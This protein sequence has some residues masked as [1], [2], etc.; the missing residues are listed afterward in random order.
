MIFQTFEKY[1]YYKI[2]VLFMSKDNIEKSI[3]DVLKSDVRFRI[4]SLLHLYPELSFSEI[5]KKMNKSKST[6]HHHLK[7]L[8]DYDIIELSRQEKVRGNILAKYYSLKPGYL[9]KL[10]KTDSEIDKA[11]PSTVEFFIAYLNFNIRNLEIYKKFFE[12]LGKREDGLEQL[13]EMLKKEES[14]SSML[15]L[16]EER[17]KKVRALYSDFTQKIN[18]I[19]REENGI[20]GVKRE[21]PFYIFTLGMS[22]K[23][24]IEGL[25]KAS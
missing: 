2:Y 4:F 25:S 14:F 18:E 10:S 15:F 20:N 19:E 7:E 8:I 3:L 12:V 17:Y 11:T 6:I 23:Q 24:V 9:E 1:K 22:L 21:K 13:K 5:S 16:S